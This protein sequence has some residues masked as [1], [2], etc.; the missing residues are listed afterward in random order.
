MAWKLQSLQ[1][2]MIGPPIRD[3]ELELQAVQPASVLCESLSPDSDIE[4]EE[5]LYYTIE[6]TCPCGVTVKLMVQASE[7]SLRGLQVCLLHDL[8]IVCPLC[9]EVVINH[10]RR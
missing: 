1:E 5:E 2:K 8:K 4:E 6:T 3:V 7:R 10:G 9:A